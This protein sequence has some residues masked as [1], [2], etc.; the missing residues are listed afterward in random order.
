ML[1]DMYFI[2][3]F[4]TVFLYLHL[5]FHLSFLLVYAYVKIYLSIYLS[6]IY[7]LNSLS[8]YVYVCLYYIIYL[9]VNLFIYLFVFLS[10]HLSIYLFSC[11]AWQ[12]HWSWFL[13]HIS[14]IA[15]SIQPLLLPRRKRTQIPFS[16]QARLPCSAKG[17]QH[18]RHRVDVSKSVKV[19][20]NLKFPFDERQ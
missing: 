11:R 6:P 2:L 10:L 13:P 7:L 4:K 16:C 5:S 17:C 12:A 18:A 3:S 15:M 8:I 9:F 14:Q 20:L 19:M 1:H